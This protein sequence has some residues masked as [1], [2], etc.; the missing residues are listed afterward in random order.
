MENILDSQNHPEKPKTNYQKWAFR[1][2]IYTMITNL[3]MAYQFA[4]AGLGKQSFID[5][6]T[7][8]IDYTIERLGKAAAPLIQMKL[9]IAEQDLMRKRAL[10]QD[11]HRSAHS[12]IIIQ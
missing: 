11:R 3:A 9:Q 6:K 1:F 5:M 7:H 12:N 4:K 10:R 8:L 2:F